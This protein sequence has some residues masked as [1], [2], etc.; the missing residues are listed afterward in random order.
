MGFVQANTSFQYLRRF[1]AMRSVLR[2]LASKCVDGTWDTRSASKRHTTR[3]LFGMSLTAGKEK[4]R[5]V[6]RFRAPKET[7]TLVS[8][9]DNSFKN[10]FLSEG[11]IRLRLPFVFGYL[12]ELNYR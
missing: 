12:G 2:A 4:G 6:S 8:N 5:D 1:V 11:A 10:C 7:G 9:R 3:V